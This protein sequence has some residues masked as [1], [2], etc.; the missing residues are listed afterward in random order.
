MAKASKNRD[1]FSW[2]HRLPRIDQQASAT[3]VLGRALLRILPT[4]LCDNR[5]KT[6]FAIRNLDRAVLP[7]FI[8]AAHIWRSNIQ[9]EEDA[10]TF[11]WRGIFPSNRQADYNLAVHVA[12]DLSHLDF[13]AAAR[14]IIAWGTYFNQGAEGHNYKLSEQ[15]E[16]EMSEDISFLEKA[17]ADD[18]YIRP[19]W[20]D[21]EPEWAARNRKEL[22]S[23]LSS[24]IW[25]D[26]IGWYRRRLKGESAENKIENAFIVL[27]Y[28]VLEGGH[29]EINNEIR[30]RLGKEALP[31]PDAQLDGASIPD[32]Q[33]AAVE[34]YWSD[35]RLVL[36]LAPAYSELDQESLTA[37]LRSLR[38]S[39]FQLSAAAEEE[40]NIDRRAVRKIKELAEQVP[41]TVPPQDRLFTIAHGLEWMAGY[42]PRVNDEWPNVLATQY[43]I[44]ALQYERSVRQF[45]RWREF[46]RNAETDRI[47][48]PDE[49]VTTDTA[50]QEIVRILR[51]SVASTVVDPLIPN[52]VENLRQSL[53]P[54]DNEYQLRDL[55]DNNFDLLAFDLLE[56]IDNVAKRL[57]ESVLSGAQSAQ[58]LSSLIPE[59]LSQLMGSKTLADGL[60]AYRKA[61]AREFPKAMGKA[62]K[63]HAKAIPTVVS[64]ALLFLIAL[65]LSGSGFIA[66]GVA[67]TT[68]AARKFSWLGKIL[69]LI[70]SK[71]A[72]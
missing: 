24:P 62:G 29:Y 45:P 13:D 58:Q 36:P 49:V 42:Q 38:E 23:A 28:Q 35:N 53:L 10:G 63:G 7:N 47:K 60:L 69:E 25:E 48:F 68:V 65:V 9:D 34:P 16:R 72:G 11:L 5:Y 21:G 39:L 26:W 4:N 17:R 6:K 67:G 31:P 71:A 61:F 14:R 54:N 2:L 15:L 46:I 19:L 44:T 37:V 40:S 12:K 50:T 30:I 1:V 52:A 3:A 57:A 27:P 20:K 41:E 66:A 55:K 56:S 8:A 18:L 22:E 64:A 59:A 51:D 32:Q 33:P 43:S 70:R